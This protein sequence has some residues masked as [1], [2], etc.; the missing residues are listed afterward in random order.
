MVSDIVPFQVAMIIIFVVII[1]TCL[2]DVV[3]VMLLFQ[4]LLRMARWLD[5]A[6]HNIMT[7]FHGLLLVAGPSIVQALGSR[8]FENTIHAPS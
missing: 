8:F 7:K 3:V 4:L 5:S 2:M 1:N 6:D